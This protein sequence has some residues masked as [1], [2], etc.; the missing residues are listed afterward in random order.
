MIPGLLP[1][2]LH[3]CE[4]KYGSGLGMRLNY[5]QTVHVF[6][7]EHN[8]VQYFHIDHHTMRN[9]HTKPPIKHYTMQYLYCNTL[10]HFYIELTTFTLFPPL[11]VNHPPAANRLGNTSSSGRPKHWNKGLPRI[12]ILMRG[13]ELEA[14]QP[15]ALHKQLSLVPALIN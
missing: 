1:I 10:Q 3:S 2:F 12:S 9:F 13:S 5:M 7:I 14:A 8:M 15:K 6:L 4:I 11:L